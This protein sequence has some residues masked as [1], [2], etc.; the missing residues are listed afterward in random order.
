MF[1]LHQEIH[2]GKNFAMIV[3]SSHPNICNCRSFS[4][5]KLFELPK[6]RRLSVNIIVTKMLSD[7]TLIENNGVIILQRIRYFL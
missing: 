3:S 7:I 1:I 2:N 4:A 6:F 5:T